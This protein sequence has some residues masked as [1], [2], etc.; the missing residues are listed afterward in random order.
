MRPL[1]DQLVGAGKHRR[2]NC[3]AKCFRGLEVDDQLDLPVALWVD[4]PVW[5]L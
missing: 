5:P 2:R 1:F 4:R 3:E